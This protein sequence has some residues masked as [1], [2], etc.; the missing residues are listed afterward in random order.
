MNRIPLPYDNFSEIQFEIIFSLN[1][2]F[3][4]ILNVLK[5]VSNENMIILI[6]IRFLVFFKLQKQFKHQTCRKKYIENI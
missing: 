6:V 4:P 1:F 5:Q 2:Q 3:F